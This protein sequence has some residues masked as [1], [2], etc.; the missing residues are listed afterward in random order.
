MRRIVLIIILIAVI[1][2]AGYMLLRPRKQSSSRPKR[3]PRD[4]TQTAD[5]KTTRRSRRQRGKT[6]GSITAKSKKE[7]REERQRRRKEERQRRRELKRREKER[8]RQLRYASRRHGRRSR[9]RGRGGPAYVIKAII[10]LDGDSY[11]LIDGRRVGVGDVV[12]GRRIVSIRPDL[13]EVEA[14]GRRSTVRVGE[15][16]LPA[17]Y[18]TTRRGRRG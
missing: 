15:S 14:F 2:L 4:T 3:T 8:K 7:L 1:G 6:T 10:S 12:M 17:T 11:A 18:V 13:L 5:V 16:L 9:R